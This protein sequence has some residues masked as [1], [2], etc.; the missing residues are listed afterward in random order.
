MVPRGVSCPPSGREQPG[1]QQWRIG[2]SACKSNPQTCPLCGATVLNKSNSW[3]AD[4][5]RIRNSE[6]FCFG[7]TEEAIVRKICSRGNR[8]RKYFHY[9]I[10][11]NM[12]RHHHLGMLEY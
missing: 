1:A 7:G 10:K 11:E 2:G 3:L 9:L 6:K 4:T 12:L 8:G 5:R